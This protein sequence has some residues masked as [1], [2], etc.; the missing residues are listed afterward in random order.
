MGASIMSNP[1]NNEI[2]N[3]IKELIYLSDNER[4]EMGKSGRILICNNYS[5]EKVS[6]SMI[7]FYNWILHEENKPDFIM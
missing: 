4:K 6:E 7:K 3:A 5:S 2:A 1:E